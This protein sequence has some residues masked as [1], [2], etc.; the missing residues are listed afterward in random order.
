MKGFFL[1]LL[2]ALA[3]AQTDFK[4]TC[5]SSSL[6]NKLATG[7]IN[8][9]PLDSYNQGANKDYYQDLTLNKFE[10]ID[11]LGYAFA[12]SGFEAGCSLNFYSL[13]IDKVEFRNQNSRMRIVVDFRNPGNGYITVWTMVSFTY[14]VVSRNLNGGFSDIWATV[15]ESTATT[16]GTSNSIDLVG[17]GYQAALSGCKVY[18]D[19][20]ML[21]N[22]AAPACRGTIATADGTAGGSLV[23]HTYIMGFRYN[24]VQSTTRYLYAGVNPVS[25]VVDFNKHEISDSTD[26]TT[27]QI[28]VAGSPY[29][30]EVVIY[31]PDNAIVYIKI[32]FVLSKF[33]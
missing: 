12:I 28:S 8:L 17:A 10:K 31:N 15:A 7:R 27:P 30:P 21:Y 20:N 2:L 9:N 26:T 22:N 33:D 29:G 6:I 19:P 4:N 32:G 14:I 18:V 3:L 1:A 11:V 25:D 5:Q 24:P 13:T 23:V 16:T